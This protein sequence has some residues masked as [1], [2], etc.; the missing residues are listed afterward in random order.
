M[1]EDNKTKRKTLTAEEKRARAEKLIAKKEAAMKKEAEQIAKLK[2]QLAAATDKSL[3]EILRANEFTEPN[4][5][6]A[7]LR[8]VEELDPMLIP[9]KKHEAEEAKKNE[10]ASAPAPQTPQN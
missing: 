3:L 10:A 5:L 8:A 9:K 1:G 4:E 2:K 6:Q 7:V